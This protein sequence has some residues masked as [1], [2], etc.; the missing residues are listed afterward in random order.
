M[1]NQVATALKTSQKRSTKS[2]EMTLKKHFVLVRIISWIV[3]D[4]THYEAVNKL[5]YSVILKY[6]QRQLGDR[7]S[8]TY[9]Q[10]RS[11]TTEYPQRQLG[12]GSDPA[13][14]VNCATVSYG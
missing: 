3:I 11:A 6:P 1:S 10:R 8:S 7:S 5:E 12:D 2:H 13:Y 4:L 9:R 14:G